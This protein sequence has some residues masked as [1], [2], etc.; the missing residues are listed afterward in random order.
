MLTRPFHLMA[1]SASS[2]CNIQCDY[3]FYLDKPHHRAMKMNDEILTNYIKNYIQ[4]APQQQV[5]FIWQGGEPTLS[6]L[7]FFQRAVTLQQRYAG[8]KTI[9]NS[10]QT[11][12]ILLNDNWCRFFKQHNFLIGISLDGT[13]SMHDGYRKNKSG[14]GTWRQV[15][16]AVDLLQK[17]KVIFN[18]LTVIH[19]QNAKCGQALYQF[20]KSLGVDYMQFIP[21]MDTPEQQAAAQDYGQLLIDV[22]DTWR[23]QDIGVIA[24]QFIEQWLMAFLGYQPSLCIFRP[25]CGDQMIIEQN[26]DIYSCDHYV[27]PQYNLGNIIETPLRQITSCIKQQ[28][29]GLAKQQLSTKCRQCEFQFACHGGC[30]KHR[31]LP[32]EMDYPH[33]QLCEA[34]YMALKH[35]APH[36]SRLANQIKNNA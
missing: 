20:L 28:Q 11:N 32:Q 24:V 9:H 6:G 27:Y 13:E 33:N 16:N 2:L 12:G 30:P 34:Y 26:G 3:C 36:L 29:F 14:K 23:Q 15:M 17:H 4:Q 7:D 10:L 25:T 21:L 18:T 5:T 35:M 1:K 19:R 31:T 22:F 8:N